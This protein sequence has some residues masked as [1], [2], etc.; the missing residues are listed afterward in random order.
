M[1][2]VCPMKWQGFLLGCTVVLWTLLTWRVLLIQGSPW[3]GFELLKALDA[4]WI[5]WSVQECK[6]LYLGKCLN[7]NGSHFA[8]WIAW[9]WIYIAAVNIKEETGREKQCQFCFWINNLNRSCP[10][11]VGV[12]SQNFFFSESL[13]IRTERQ[14]HY[15]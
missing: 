13:S 12:P 1:D 9:F 8:D 7:L 3:P 15:F 14:I 11:I 2:Q 10:I 4:C 5:Q 6:R